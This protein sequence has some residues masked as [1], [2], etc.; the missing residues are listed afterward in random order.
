MDPACVSPRDILSEPSYVTTEYSLP[1]P[2][3]PVARYGEAFPNP[4]PWPA[5]LQVE[6]VHAL[7]NPAEPPP[8]QPYRLPIPFV[9]LSRRVELAPETPQVEFPADFDAAAAAPV[10]AA[11]T[12]HF[13]P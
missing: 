10:S 3:I 12:R 7:P 9:P 8:F 5:V 4:Y 13:W 6:P 1:P 11:R 2:F